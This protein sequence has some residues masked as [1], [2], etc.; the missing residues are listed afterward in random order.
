MTLTQIRNQIHS[1]QRKF[2]KELAVFRLRQLAEEIADDW[3]IAT[4]E[5]EQRPQPHQ[6]VRRVAAAG[7]TLKT[8]MNLNNYVQERLNKGECLIPQQIVLALLPWAWNHRYDD[9]LYQDIPTTTAVG[10][11]G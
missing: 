6:V 7:H 11:S 1:L 4:A 2:A 10:I 8:Y 9:I 3:A 5:K